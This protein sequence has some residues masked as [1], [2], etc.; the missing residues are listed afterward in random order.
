[1]SDFM[2]LILWLQ[3]HSVVLVFA[4]FVMLVASIYWPGRKSRFERDSRLIF[5]DER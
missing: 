3:H 4:V 2:S 5:D 1:M